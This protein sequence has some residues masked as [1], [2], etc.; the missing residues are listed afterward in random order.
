MTYGEISCTFCILLLVMFIAFC[1]EK[2]KKDG[3]FKLGYKAS[4][5]VRRAFSTFWL[6]RSWSKGKKID[7]APCYAG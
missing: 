3:D 7:E 4:V 2:K 1:V 5:L 6:C